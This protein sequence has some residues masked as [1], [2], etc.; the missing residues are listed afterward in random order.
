MSKNLVRIISAVNA[1]VMMC[2]AA[3]VFPVSVSA[4]DTGVIFESEVEKI[5]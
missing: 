3:A 4:E 1:A 2:S 5:I